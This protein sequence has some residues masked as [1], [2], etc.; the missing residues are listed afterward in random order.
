[1][2]FKCTGFTN[3]LTRR[4]QVVK[5]CLLYFRVLTA[6]AE[7]QGELEEEEHIFRGEKRCF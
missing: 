3:D 1:M 6:L 4:R 7:V 2:L 5:G